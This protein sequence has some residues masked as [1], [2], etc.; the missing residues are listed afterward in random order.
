MTDPESKEDINLGFSEILNA[1]SSEEIAEP[2]VE[3]VTDEKGIEK[4][5]WI[6]TQTS[7]EEIPT[8]ML[9]GIFEEACEEIDPGTIS[10]KDKEQLNNTAKLLS[11][12]LINSEEFELS[13]SVLE[14]AYRITGVIQEG[15][16]IALDAALREFPDSSQLSTAQMKRQLRLL[17]IKREIEDQLPPP[18][19]PAKEDFDPFYQ[20]SPITPGVDKS[21]LV[22]A[23]LAVLLFLTAG[24]FLFHFIGRQDQSISLSP[25]FSSFEEPSI[26]PPAVQPNKDLSQ[27]AMVYYDI[28]RPGVVEKTVASAPLID[29]R[30]REAEKT[31]QIQPLQKEAASLRMDG[32]YESRRIEEIFN[33]SS[34]SESESV[35]DDD[36]EFPNDRMDRES[37]RRDRD[38]ERE[39][40]DA[41]RRLELRPDERRGGAWTKGDRY[42][43]LINTSVMDRPSF[44]SKEV[45]ELYVGD[46]IVVEARLGRWL[47]IR[48]VK[49]EPGFILAQDAEKVFD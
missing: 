19:A 48:S 12:K 5:S 6:T 45:A 13:S 46:Y 34:R 38:R 41:R 40:Y 39:I 15:L 16:L 8:S 44:K 2:K 9:V 23:A 33:G 26:V 10:T 42:E 3:E 4:L 11:E 32:P 17:G 7:N 20:E 28:D 29:K 14:K 27:L 18:E 21:R 22:G 25:D 43:I 31:D 36:R 35:Y 47:R 1:E 24:Y 30:K 37:S 49:G